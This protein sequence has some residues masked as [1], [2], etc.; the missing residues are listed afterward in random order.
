MILVDSSVWID[1]FNGAA[2]ET[3]NKLDTLLGQ[4]IIVVG[5]LILIEVLQGFRSD[6]DYHTA[7]ALFANLL[8]FDMIGQDIAIQSADNYRLLRK[9][10]ITIRKTI[11]VIIATFCKAHDFTLFHADRNFDLI[12]QVLKVKILS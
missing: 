1:Y 2:T 12:A 11:D 8:Y 4:E 6:S 10:G 9:N 5:D 7:K 3:V